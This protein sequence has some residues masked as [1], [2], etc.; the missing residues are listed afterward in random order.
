MK[1]TI[2]NCNHCGI[3]FEKPTNEYNRCMRKKRNVYCSH[4]CAGVGKIVN[5]GDKIN[6]IPPKHKRI[7]DPFKYYLNNSKRRLK[8]EIDI[9]LTYLEELWEKQKGICPYTKIKLILN[10]STKKDIKLDMRYTASL[11]RIDSSKGYI[12]GNVQFI[13]MAINLMK[14]TMSHEHTLEFLTQITNNLLK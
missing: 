7:A 11:D 2:C 10:S 3:S 1:M 12:K 14:N 5:F 4:K 6:R 9:D 8:H 13:S